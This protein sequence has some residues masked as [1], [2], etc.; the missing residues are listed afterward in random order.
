MKMVNMKRSTFI[1]TIVLTSVLFGAIGVFASNGV[2]KITA[3]L[4][5]NIAFKLNGKTWVPRDPDG[6][7][8]SP[9]VYAGTSYLPTRA[10]AE[11]VGGE[12]R[13]DGKTETISI[14]S[15]SASTSSNNEGIPYKDGKES[16]NSDT[17]KLSRESGVM[18]LAGSETQMTNKLKEHAVSII[19]LY[20][21]A[22]ESGSTHK[23]DQFIDTYVSELVPNSPMNYTRKEQKDRF[24]EQIESM[25][26]NNDSTIIAKYVKALRSVTTSDIEPQYVSEKTEFSQSFQLVYSP[27]DFRTSFGGSVYID[28]EFSA[29][30]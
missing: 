20:A 2:E 16:D 29:E 18:M 8:L 15:G 23:F 19:D 3:Y 30:I 5:H 27:K 9:I 1:L 6:I 13:W 17:E 4:N 21:D 11:A 12:V 7:K 22:L 26:D 28:F 24:K 25:R 14:N 10:V